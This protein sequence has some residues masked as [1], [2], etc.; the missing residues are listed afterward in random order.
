MFKK[1]IVVFL[2][3]LFLVPSMAI[4]QE[5][6]GKTGGGGT[7]KLD[8]PLGTDSPQELIGKIINAVLGVVGSIALLMFIYGGLVWMT[9]A[10]NAERVQKGKDILIWAALGIVIIFASYALVKFVFVSIGVS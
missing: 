10:G 1:I 2:V 9:A 5:G 7:V 3:V 4:A 6:S 8:N